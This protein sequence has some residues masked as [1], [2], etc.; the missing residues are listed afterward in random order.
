MITINEILGKRNVKIVLEKLE[1]KSYNKEKHHEFI[2]YYQLNKEELKNKIIKFD[3]IPETVTL[4]EIIN[5]KGKKR[6]VANLDIKDK[7]LSKAIS[8]IL[9]KYI[10]PTLSKYSYAYRPLGGTLEATKQVREYILKDYSIV[11]QLDIKDFF[12]SIN[13]EILLNKLKKYNIE[14]CVLTLIKNYLKCPIEIELMETIKNKGL[15]QGNPMSPILSNIY[16]DGFDKIL[17]SNSIKFIRFCDDINVFGKNKSEI[18]NSIGIAEKTLSEKFSLSLNKSKTNI[19]NVYKTTFLGYYLVRENNDIEIIKKE[20]A[21]LSY[22]S[23]WRTSAL[24]KENNE[25][26]IINDGILTNA[27][28]SILFENKDKKVYIPVE[29]TNSINIYSNAI[30]S[31]NFFNTINANN[32]I[33]NIYDKFNRYTGRFIPNNSRKSCL[34]LLKQVSIYNNKE[35]RLE[36]SKS[37]ISAGIHNLKS[38][39]KYYQRR[40]NIDIKDNIKAIEKLEIDLINEK[41]YVRLLLIEARIREK[42]YSCFNQILKNEDFYFYSRTKRPPKD[43]INSLI[44]FG[45]TLLYN[46]F[47]K[48]IYKTTL[49]IR[50][51]YLHASNNRYESLNLDFADIFK[52][53]IIDRI[54]FK[55]INKRIINSKIH[56]E[57][58]NNGVYINDDGKRIFIKEY[59]DKLQETLV[60]KGK[61]I[62]YENIMKKEIYKL[63]D[64]IRNDF[65]FK[66]FRYY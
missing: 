34:T 8:E 3:Y 36:F 21:R 54:I 17:E 43:A 35:K 2:N 38:N 25:Y 30:F 28:Y 62:S 52:P 57:I 49:D 10:D 45:N 26:H 20:K 31:S 37:I 51:G 23:T 1:Q 7:F 5:F 40:Y 4:K 60:I 27:D 47:A 14:P 19:T 16:L 18:E 41:D 44:S 59:Q 55:L 46:F 42:Y 64:S 6:L 61:K 12:E 15:L 33:V 56:F 48:E 22:H 50:I 53:L 39:L 9:N 63:L 24:R 13:H 66:G 58:R 11:A 32:I 65:K 29:T